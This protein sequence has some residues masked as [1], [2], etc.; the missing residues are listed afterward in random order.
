MSLWKLLKVKRFSL[1]QEYLYFTAAVLF[2]TIGSSL[3]LLYQTLDTFEKERQ[4]ILFREAKQ[5]QMFFDE[6]IRYV[7]NLLQFIGTK[8]KTAPDQSLENVANMIKYHR[9]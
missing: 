7:E 1:V 4:L 3:F 5:L 8:I 9:A 2:M 6:R